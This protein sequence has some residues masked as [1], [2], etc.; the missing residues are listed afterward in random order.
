MKKKTSVVWLLFI[1]FAGV[2]FALPVVANTYTYDN[3]NRLTSVTY[4]SGQ[5]I[6]YTYD[7]AG[8]MTTASNQAVSSLIA[9]PSSVTESQTFSQT[10]TLTLGSGSFIDGIAADHITLEGDLTGLTLGNVSKSAANKITLQ[11]SGI[12]HKNTGTGKITVSAAGTGTNAVTA[13]ISVNFSQAYG[14]V[15]RDQITDVGDAIL[16]LQEIVGLTQFDNSQ[17]QLANVDG[18]I[19]ENSNPT[20]D[21]GDAILILRHI[22][23]LINSYPIDQ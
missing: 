6:T 9:D 3:L 13:D 4:S 19:D 23:G 21:V 15:N 16:I 12:L 10:F 8:N 11:I 1:L 5:K 7:A 17:V 2:C 18:S 20:I 22:V 14:D